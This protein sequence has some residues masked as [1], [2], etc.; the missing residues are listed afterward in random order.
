M[1]HDTLDDPFVAHTLA[2]LTPDWTPDATRARAQLDEAIDGRHMPVRIVVTGAAVALVAALVCAP[3]TR[4]LAQALWARW[5]MTRVEIVSTPAAWPLD[6]RYSLRGSG[7]FARQADVERV[8]GYALHLP[9]PAIA[10]TAVEFTVVESATVDE[11]IDVAA[12]ETALRRVGAG[13]VAVPHAWNG[14]SIR[15][16]VGNVIVARYPDGAIVAQS[17]TLPSLEVPVGIPL[18]DLAAI[19][20][21]AAGLPAG[22]ARSAGLAYAISPAW[23]LQLDADGRETAQRLSLRNGDAWLMSPTAPIA[24]AGQNAPDALVLRADA[25]RLYAVSASRERAI[26]IAGA[27]P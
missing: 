7:T 16:S 20:F 2:A 12:L 10:G 23:L 13:D 25:A 11:R 17:A 3:Q 21:R 15:A 19:V 8:G 4:M 6:R 1:A 22:A 27:I 9:S 5:P 26:E 24:G 18:S 14:A